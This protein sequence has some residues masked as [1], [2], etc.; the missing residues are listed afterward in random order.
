MWRAL[1][2]VLIC[3]SAFPAIAGDLAPGVSQRIIR[4]YVASGTETRAQTI[5]TCFDDEDCL[6]RMMQTLNRTGGNPGL[7]VKGETAVAE[8]DGLLHRFTYLPEKG[9]RFC[10]AE[11]IKMSVAPTFTSRAPTMRMELSAAGAEV[12]ITLPENEERSWFDGFLI[13]YGARPGAQKVCTLTDDAKVYECRGRCE[14][15]GF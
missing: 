2:A 11:F 6:N 1:S 7:L 13:L 9:E 10:A 12:A 4:L 15:G 8:T 5:E 14:S 3:L